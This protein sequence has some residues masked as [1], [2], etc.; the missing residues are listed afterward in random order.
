MHFYSAG[1]SVSFSIVVPRIEPSTYLFGRQAG[2]LY[3]Q[4]A[5]QH[6]QNNRKNHFVYALVQAIIISPPPPPAESPC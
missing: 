4:S 1:L 3:N 2:A 5:M 6:I